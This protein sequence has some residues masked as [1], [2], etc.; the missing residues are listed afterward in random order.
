MTALLDELG[1]DAVDNGGLDNSWRHQ[2]GTPA[3]G[4][5][6]DVEKT[7]RLLAE[8]SPERTAKFSG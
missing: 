5:D 6:G 2:P 8:A 3:Y 1:F 7:T 4:A